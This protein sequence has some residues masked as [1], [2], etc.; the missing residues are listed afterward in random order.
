MS[1]LTLRLPRSTHEQ[2]KALAK[3]EEVSINQLVLTAV[4]EKI[5]ALRTARIFSGLKEP[6]SRERFEAAL[7]QVPD[8]E[9]DPWDRWTEG[10]DSGTDAGPEIS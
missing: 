10:S 9:P 6:V 8:G 5:A 7:A 4:A 3:E 2:L 1:N